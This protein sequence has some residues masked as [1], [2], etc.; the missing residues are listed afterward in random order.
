MT[1][2]HKLRVAFIFFLLLLLYM[3]VLFNLY[4]IQIKQQNF[5]KDLATKQYA[6]TVTHMPPRA[7]IYDRNGE[8]LAINHDSLAAFLLPK[9]IKDKQEVM[10]FL[11]KHFPEAAEKLKTTDKHFMYIQR[12]LTEEQIKLI[13]K[14]K[15]DDIQILKEP[16]RYYSLDAAAPVVGVT[17][18]DNTGIAGIE[19]IFNDRLAGKASSC[20]LEKDARSGHFY[21]T[22]ELIGSG[23]QGE[24]ITLTIDSDLQYL[25]F[26]E[27]KRSI[28][29]FK[30]KE[31]SVLI[32]DPDSGD[33]L[34]MVS[35]PTFDPNNTK[36]ISLDH[37]KN[38]VLTDAHEPGS[39]IKVY[40]ALAA[41]EEGVV[42]PEELIDCENTKQGYVN[43]ARFGTL[44]PHGV[45][46]FADVVAYSNN[47][48]VAKV[49]TRLGP[50]LYDHYKAVGFGEKSVLNWPGEQKG[51]I[52]PPRNWSRPSIVSLSFGYEIR[53]TIL[54]LATALSIVINNGIPVI[55]RLLIN[56][57]LPVPMTC[58]QPLYSE[59][60]LAAVRDILERT[61]MKG[62]ARRA[63]IKGYNV[64][65][66]TGTAN[67]V[68]DGTYSSDH[69]IFTF[70]GIVEKGN[71]RRIIVTFVKDAGIKNL[72]ATRTAVPLFEKVAEKMLIHDK[73]L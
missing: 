68:V 25:A 58:K 8:P 32:M 62:T 7:A 72:R 31:G 51:F 4:L 19:M 27:L 1:N 56:P 15:L 50:K 67:L 64:I 71:Y 54:Q 13:E 20:L 52:N 44:V 16:S 39:V 6:T 14:S 28:D 57:E 69:N 38:R 11:N 37:M 43:G 49:A 65:G 10:K 29:S 36:N 23:K 42:T 41:L 45:I 18:I 47:I 48:G 33:I 60:T 21:F 55:P 3:L 46:P 61:T 26:E 73:V 66:K 30:A 24:P 9:Q 17:D 34:A 35:Y 40:L 70:S 22:K 63:R 5:Y 53:I 59:E 2:S 12:K